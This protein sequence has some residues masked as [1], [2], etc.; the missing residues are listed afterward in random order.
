MIPR[1]FSELSDEQ[2]ARDA[3]VSSL[4]S[5]KIFSDTGGT[6]ISTIP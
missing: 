5:E 3:R 6:M 4:V 1:E 2:G